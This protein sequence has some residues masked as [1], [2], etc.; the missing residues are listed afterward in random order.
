MGLFGGSRRSISH[1]QTKL[2]ALRVQTS[3]LGQ[4]LV[5]QFGT[6]RIPGKLLSNNDF[7]AIAHTTTESTGGKG[8]G[9][10]TTTTNT[11]YTYTTAA[12]IFLCVGKPKIGGILSWW[13][14]KGNRKTLGQQVFNST[15]PASGPFTRQ[16]TAT[17]FLMDLGCGLVA[18][19][20][21]TANDY[22]DDSYGHGG[23]SISITGEV[24]PMVK[25]AS[26]PAAGQ[27]SVDGTG[28]YTFN[29]ADASKSIQIRYIKF[30][31]STSPLAQSGFTLFDGSQTAGWG[32]LTS[33]HPGQDLVHPFWAKVANS[34]IDCGESGQMQ[35][36]QWEV[37]GLLLYPG[38]LDSNPKDIINFLLTDPV[39]GASFPSANLDALTQYSN[40]CIAN[41]L[42]LSPGYEA[43]RT[44]AECIQELCD[45][46]NS[47][48][49][50]SE[51]KLK[52]VPYGDQTVLGNGVTYTPLA[53]IYDLTR[54]DF[55]GDPGTPPIEVIPVSKQDIWNSVSVEY[56]NRAADYNPDVVAE[57]DA[58]QI[59]LYGLRKQDPVK[60]HPITQ[61]VV[62]AIVANMLLKKQ[63]RDLFVY[64]FRLGVQY[65]LLEQMDLNTITL[66]EMGFNK[67]PVRLTSIIENDDR[68]FDIEAVDFPYASASATLYPKGE[69]SGFTTNNNNDPGDV[70]APFIYEPLAR[71]TQDGLGNEV[72][73]GAYGAS[74]DWGGA[75]VWLSN[76]NNTYRQVG[77]IP[78][79]MRSGITASTL[80]AAADPDT[81]HTVDVDLSTS[82]GALV[83]AT[84]TDCDNFRS[85]MLLNNELISFKDVT[86]LGANQ[87]RLGTRLRRGVYGTPI[88]THALSERAVRIDDNILKLKFK[89]EDVGQQ[90]YLKFTSYNTFG[91]AEQ[92]LA[93]VTAY[94]FTLVGSNGGNDFIPT[95]L[96]H[97]A[98]VLQASATGA[99]TLLVQI[100][101]AVYTIVAGDT[102]EYD[103]W[104]DPTSADFKAGVDIIFGDATT[105]RG[106]G[107]R[108]QVPLSADPST[109]LSA[110]AKS[111]WFH[112]KIDLSRAAGKATATWMIGFDGSAV[113]FH[114]AKFANIRIM[115]GKT[116]KATGWITGVPAFSF[117]NTSTN[118]T[119]GTNPLYSQND[120]GQ[121]YAM[122][123]AGLS[124][125]MN[126][127]G[128]IIPTPS[129]LTP[130]AYVTQDDGVN[131]PSLIWRWVTI[132]CYRPDQSFFTIASSAAQW[133]AVPLAPT[134]SQAAGGARA[135]ATLFARVAY[136]KDGMIVGVS[137]QASLA[138]LINNTL[139]LVAPGNPV[140]RSSGILLSDTFAGV[141]GTLLSAHAADTAFGSGNGVGNVWTRV[142]TGND[143]KLNGSGKI[144]N[145]TL[146][147]ATAGYL[148]DSNPQQDGYT[149]LFDIDFSASAANTDYFGVLVRGQDNSGNGFS[150]NIRGDGKMRIE[151][152]VAGAVSTIQADTAITLKVGTM[153][154]VVSTAAGSTQMDCYWNNTLIFSKQDASFLWKIGERVG[155]YGGAAAVIT[156]AN[157]SCNDGI[158]SGNAASMYD[159][160][161]PLVGVTTGKEQCQIDP[162]TP[163]AF[164]VGWTEP[165]AGATH[166]ATLVTGNT[167]GGDFL[168]I[169][170]CI[171]SSATSFF[172][173]AMVASEKGDVGGLLIVN[174][175]YRFYPAVPSMSPYVPMRMFGGAYPSTLDVA[176][177]SQM[178]GDNFIAMANAGG[179]TAITPA[180]PGGG[181]TGGGGGCPKRGHNIFAERGKVFGTPYKN[182]HW[183]LVRTENGGI[184]QVVP[185][186]RFTTLRGLIRAQELNKEETGI[187]IIKTKVR[188]TG[189]YEWSKV[190]SAEPMIEDA[191][192]ESV[193]VEQEDRLYF[194]GAPESTCDAE[195]HNLKP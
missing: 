195:G 105:I 75:D 115:N 127:Q 167:N 81:T 170:D 22:G 46:T 97:D 193:L 55:L 79:K 86:L 47:A 133:G 146:S 111:A 123:V 114:R 32:Y 187:D 29:S 92:Q 84:T 67:K 69:G 34:A 77:S 72:W 109:D 16:P 78:G 24:T 53:P 134:L 186:H 5:L 125:G 182:K 6:G 149:V 44:F 17:G 70:A 15:V 26:A 184:F 104:I 192:A 172:A 156:G 194:C 73:V 138:V 147:T 107:Y 35:N 141:S 19:R 33:K 12:E 23:R 151:K 116:V 112:R 183:V 82:G 18:S 30:S 91:R 120:G 132:T 25:V 43:Q 178:M 106:N 98:L 56:L 60:Y 153:K 64:K 88:A 74:A 161:V 121:W 177:N 49:F 137:K 38:Q 139:S 162:R 100:A 174:T 154:V 110:Y 188:A 83:N 42:F 37:A 1:E 61:K 158:A 129:S 150:V 99:G 95:E 80:A 93:N 163:L 76:D 152:R 40:W 4:P 165:T 131:F 9:S 52:I 71:A 130:F 124:S 185:R 155:C 8:G 191:E 27:Y 144:Q 145:T 119:I 39:F 28:T 136:V 169:T 128:S 2:H 51:G 68:T 140:P 65:D 160:W 41:G 21:V 96:V 13:D 148:H 90:F 101:G 108:D 126:T 159:G 58:A 102:L 66:P 180:A 31:A 113:G 190:I 143:L 164:N 176:K 11:T 20:S 87:Y 85:M 63:T 118:F 89:A 179:M 50:E 3:A 45:I 57:S 48:P 157:F 14:T 62:A 103:I 181:G 168:A 10:G 54:D 122:L 189:K 36:Y 59:E 166:T 135:A 94:T 117:V 171:S 173:G 7:T 175:T 142:I